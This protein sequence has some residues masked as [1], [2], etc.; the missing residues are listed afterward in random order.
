MEYKI[1]NYAVLRRDGTYNYTP[2]WG[3][4][5]C[6]HSSVPY[7][8]VELNT[9][10]QTVAVWV[11]LH[12]TVTIC[13]I[14]SPSFQVLDHQLLEN[15]CLQLQ[16]PVIM[17]DDF[18]AY[19]TLWGSATVDAQGREVEHFINNHNINIMNKGAPTRISYDTETAIDLTMC[20]L[21]LEADLHWSISSREMIQRKKRWKIR[22]ARW[23][24]YE[25]SSQR[26]D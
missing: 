26:S 2:H 9:L 24:L 18:N 5:I 22:E 17:L 20:S 25:S 8:T 4:A 21:N 23:V 13:N 3:V 11:Q 12:T 16:Q 6:V 10:I 14:Y 15:I 19:N 7:S 1:P